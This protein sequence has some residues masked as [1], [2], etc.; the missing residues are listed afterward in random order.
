MSMLNAAMPT[1][2]VGETVATYTKYEGAQK[3]VSTLIAQ[4]VPARDIAIVGQALRTVE[5]VTGKLGWARAAWQGAL[6]GIM[7][8]LLFAAFAVIWSPDLAM[9]MIGGILL[10]GVG[11]G[12]A[13]RLLSY[14]IVRRRRDY[15]SIMAVSADRYEVTVMSAHV[16]EARRLLGTTQP[17][18]Q[19]VQPPTDEPPKYGIRLSDQQAARPAETTEPA[20]PETSADRP[21]D[22]RA[23]SGD[24]EAQ[25]RD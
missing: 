5:K 9:P 21:A 23:S 13:F 18:T 1:P 20:A 8:G 25:S 7:I 22:G 4:D 16:A 24:S 2:E 17:R 19:V 10:I 11:F 6:N 3:A 14:S 12:M 15:A